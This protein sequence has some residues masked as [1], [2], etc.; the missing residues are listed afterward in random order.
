MARNLSDIVNVLFAEIDKLSSDKLSG[1]ELESQLKRSKAIID[2]SKQMV[3]VGRLGLDAMK[4]RDD[5]I[6]A[7][8]IPAILS[9]TDD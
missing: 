6:S 8:K 4:A 1:V 5:L 9:L 2:I 3:E 7:C